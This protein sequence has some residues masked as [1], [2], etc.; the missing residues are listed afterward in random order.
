[1]LTG[2]TI[3]K[4]YIRYFSLLLLC[5]SLLLL[6]ETKSAKAMII[7][8]QT[9]FVWEELSDG[10]VKITG[11]AFYHDLVS[12]LEIPE[13]IY[14]KTVSAI[15]GWSLASGCNKVEEIVLPD[16]VSILEEEAFAGLMGMDRI[17]VSE[18]NPYFVVSDNAL[19]SKDKKKLY[20]VSPKAKEFQIPNGVEWIGYYTFLKDSLV[21]SIYISDEVNLASDGVSVYSLASNIFG[22]CANL[23]RFVVSGTHPY[24]KTSEGVLY[25]KDGKK[26]LLVPRNYGKDTFIV[27][28]GVTEIGSEAFWNCTGIREILFSDSVESLSAYSFKGCTGLQRAV[29]PEKVTLIPYYAFIGCSSLREI[30]LPDDLYFIG[31]M[32]FDSC[33]NLSSVV[34][35]GEEVDEIRLAI[36]SGVKW[37]KSSSESA[38]VTTDEAMFLWETNNKGNV[39]ITGTKIKKSAVKIVIPNKIDGKTVEEIANRAFSGHERLRSVTIPETVLVIGE[40]A[41]YETPALEEIKVAKDNP[42]YTTAEGNLYNKDISYLVWVTADVTETFVIPATVRSMSRLAFSSCKKLTTIHI[43]TNGKNPQES[44]NIGTLFNDNF[45]QCTSLRGIWVDADHPY[46]LS[47]D[48]VLFTRDGKRLLAVPPAFNQKNY[49]VPYNVQEIGGFSFSGCYKIETVTIPDGIATIELFAFMNCPSIKEITVGHGL[50]EIGEKAF[51]YCEALEKVTLPSTLVYMDAWAMEGCSNLTELVLPKENES[52]T[53]AFF[54]GEEWFGELSEPGEEGSDTPIIPEPQQ[55]TIPESPQPIPVPQAERLLKQRIRKGTTLLFSYQVTEDN[56]V[57]ITGLTQMAEKDKKNRILTIPQKINEMPVVGIDE[58]AFAKVPL[59]YISLPEGLLEIGKGAFYGC[60]LSTVTIPASVRYIGQRVFGANHGMQEINVAEENEVYSSLGGVL[61]N[62]ERTILFQMPANYP[63]S[64][65]TIPKSVRRLDEYAFG[66]CRNLETAYVSSTTLQVEK[67]VYWNTSAELVLKTFREAVEWVECRFPTMNFVT[68]KDVSHDLQDDGTMKLQ[69]KKHN[70]QVIYALRSVVDMAYC[71]DFLVKLQNE[72]GE[73]TVVL[74]DEEMQEVERIPLGKTAGIEKISVTPKYKGKLEY[75]GFVATDE[76]IADYSAFE[77]I[78][79]YIYIFSMDPST[80]KVSYVMTDLTEK[81]H[82]NVEH[83][84]QEDGS[85]SMAFDRLYGEIKLALPEPIDMS[86]YD[87]VGLE[88][89]SEDGV[90]ALRFYDE[91]FQEIEGFY[92]I[93]TAGVMERMHIP[94]TESMVYGIGLM[95]HDK[96]RTGSYHCEATVYSISF[97]N[98]EDS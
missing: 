57:I 13:S 62:K 10:T 74:Y 49:V 14:G 12:R 2:G 19:Y 91:S 6:G 65:Y 39:V 1:M 33:V 92:E 20:W 27:P 67:N 73:I 9:E 58:S 24:Y 83:S 69:Y 93:K 81:Q 63:E 56:E 8:D 70:G 88:L 75:V 4:K 97:Y 3:L 96:M 40:E 42:N 90:F 45:S 38:A 72:V 48:G 5:G 79:Y 30:V 41:F 87:T 78:V 89:E 61:Y 31:G 84:Y 52:L 15:G 98:N 7:S 68:A 94:T 26:L 76:E 23:K 66:N 32:A 29:I 64:H 80:E 71:K 16:T 25:S 50:T 35:A 86:Y 34:Y 43:Q 18:D 59:T 55:P 54:D 82:Y 22:E 85:L 51:Y 28:E 77:A 36:E 46:Y 37:E 11:M 60:N 47:T 44:F 53:N 21:E 95:T 17:S